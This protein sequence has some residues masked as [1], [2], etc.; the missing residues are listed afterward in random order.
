MNTFK[1]K[2]LSTMTACK[3]QA[4][5]FVQTRKGKITLATTLVVAATGASA[6]VAPAVGT[7][8]YDLYDVGVNDI[9]KGAPGFI[10]GMVGIIFSATKMSENWKL[11]GLGILASTAVIKAD[12]I[13]SSLG[14]LL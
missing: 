1:K 11:A 10:G 13:T 2:A 12:T 8:A 9:L 7:F 14:V 5:A 3:N 6:I 4:L